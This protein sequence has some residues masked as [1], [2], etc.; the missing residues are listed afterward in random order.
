MNQKY[1]DNGF[2]VKKGLF[3]KEELQDLEK[4]LHTFHDSWIDKNRSFY[5]SKAIN[6]AYIT[7]SQHLVDADRNVVFNFIGSK[8]LMDL[9]YT[10]IPERPC[11]MNTQLFFDPVNAEQKNYWHRDSQYLM[12]V[13]EQKQALS[14]PNVIHF[15]IPLRE[16]RGVELVPRSHQCW[17]TDEELKI[18]LEKEGRSNFEDLSS[19]LAVALDVG[20]MLVFS[21]NMIHRGLYGKGRLSL[22]ILFCDPEPAFAEFVD[23]DCLPGE[24]ALDDIE[25]PSTFLNMMALKC[26]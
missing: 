6:S 10:L 15:R 16:E 25:D 8:K 21:A 1:L 13:E 11:F 23:T 24:K 5:E 14:G 26:N 20:D 22:D 9:V 3:E 4:A 18:R 17:D 2:L 12:T 7:G 19:G